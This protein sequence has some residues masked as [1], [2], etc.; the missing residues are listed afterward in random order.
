VATIR[1]IH[2]LLESFEFPAAWLTPGS[3]GLNDAADPEPL[4]GRRATRGT[5]LAP[6]STPGTVGVNDHSSALGSGPLVLSAGNRTA[7]NTLSPME[8]MEGYRQL[9]V[10]YVDPHSQRHCTVLADVHAYVNQSPSLPDRHSDQD[11]MEALQSAVRRMARQYR[12]SRSAPIATDRGTHN[13]AIRYA[14]EGKGLPE[15][16]AIY[17]GYALTL[18]RVSPAGLRRYCDHSPMLGLDC[19]GF[20]NCYFM[21]TGRLAHAQNISEYLRRGELQRRNSYAEIQPLDV[22]I[23][24]DED[25]GAVGHI[26]VVDSVT[27]NNRMW[28]VESSGSKEGL[29]A[30]EYAVLEVSN[31]VFRVDRG[32]DAHGHPDDSTHVVIVPVA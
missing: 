30:T 20:V 28:V 29:A 24:Q 7:G 22:L 27:Q 5:A 32:F 10:R 8:F 1:R 11:E 21:S 16:Y 18:G 17:L 12:H 31:G 13:L 19:S 4:S 6:D 26:A 9:G 23:W 15:D 25:G 2:S 3:L 14:Y